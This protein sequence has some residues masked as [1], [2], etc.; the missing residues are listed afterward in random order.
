MPPLPVLTQPSQ[1]RGTLPRP[2]TGSRNTPDARPPID[3]NRPLPPPPSTSADNYDIP[4]LRNRV[5]EESSSSNPPKH[6]RSFSHPF[7]SFF[8]SKRA[9]KKNGNRQNIR[10]PEAGRKP[11][12]WDED[13]S[14]GTPSVTPSQSRSDRQPVTGRCMTC[15][16]TVRWPQGLKVFR[17]TTC[18]TINDLEPYVED[19]SKL[20]DGGQ[21]VQ[22]KG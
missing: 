1:S 2:I 13:S 4:A 16:S 12:E 8:G 7:P 3:L 11:N 19:Q 5:L 17:C 14:A 9:D 22:F 20:T 18:L 6:N 15:D 10:T 21:N